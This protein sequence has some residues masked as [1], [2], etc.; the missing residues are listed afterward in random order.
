M[1]NRWRHRNRYLCVTSSECECVRFHKARFSAVEARRRPIGLWLA[2]HHHEQV[3]CVL[4][5]EHPQVKH[6]ESEAIV[7]WS[8]AEE[9]ELSIHL[10]LADSNVAKLGRLPS[11]L[12]SMDPP[13]YWAV[14]DAHAS[15]VGVDRLPTS[16]RVLSLS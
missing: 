8:V 11:T 7:I 9:I 5:L 13:Y 16:A 14:P 15:H 3:G 10:W 2:L 4:R 6:S 1:S 12:I